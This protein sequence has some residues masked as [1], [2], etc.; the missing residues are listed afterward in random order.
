MLL[1]ARVHIIKAGTGDDRRATVDTNTQVD[2]QLLSKDF[3][4]S[5][6]LRSRVPRT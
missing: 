1:K 6:L 3:G 2:P 4:V 5:C